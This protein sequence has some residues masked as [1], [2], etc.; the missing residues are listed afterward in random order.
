MPELPPIR[1]I[2]AMGEGVADGRKVQRRRHKKARRSDRLHFENW[3]A[4]K[5]GKDSFF[6]LVA[7]LTLLAVT[8]DDGFFF[9][10]ALLALAAVAS[11]D[12]FFFLVA[13]LALTAVASEGE[14][15]EKKGCGEDC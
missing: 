6:L 8:S 9:L 14:T 15:C 3:E 7:L 2:L 11:D 13:F 10:V 12:S 4:V 1:S 5:L